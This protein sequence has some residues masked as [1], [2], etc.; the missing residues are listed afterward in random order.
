MTSKKQ[1]RAN[2]QNAQKST[3]PKSKSGKQRAA[4]NAIKHGL[5][6]DILLLPHEDAEALATLKDSLQAD[7][8]P[9]THMQA[10]II[11]R[12]AMLIWRE[13]RLALSEAAEIRAQQRAIP[14]GRTLSGKISDREIRNT[15]HSNAGT[16]DLARMLLIG[17]YQTMVSNQIERTLKQYFDL[18]EREDIFAPSEPITQAANDAAATLEVSVSLED[19]A[20]MLNQVASRLE[21]MATKRSR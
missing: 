7:F 14:V 2:R 5:F 12:L 16:L 18:V 20:E 9:V 17:R 19:G 1:I 11:D 13:R 3:G 21:A 8:K 10:V 4:R 6:T 15:A